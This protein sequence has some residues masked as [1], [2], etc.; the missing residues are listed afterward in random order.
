MGRLIFRQN[1]RLENPTVDSPNPILFQFWSPFQNVRSVRYRMA[2]SQG[3]EFSEK[4]LFLGLFDPTVWQN[5]D[6]EM[7]AGVTNTL[8]IPL[9]F[10]DLVPGAMRITKKGQP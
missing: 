8:Y 6:V 2:L 4:I 3:S 5:E 7:S 10:T 9:K 1:D